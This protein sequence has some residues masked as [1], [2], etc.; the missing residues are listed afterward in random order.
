M[1]WLPSDAFFVKRA[2]SGIAIKTARSLHGDKG[3]MSAGFN[4]PNRAKLYGE[5]GKK[6]AARGGRKRG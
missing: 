2:G 3:C 1:E 5:P 6:T 4:L